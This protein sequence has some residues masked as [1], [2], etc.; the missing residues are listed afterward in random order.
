MLLN[1]KMYTGLAATL[2]ALGVLS[3]PTFAASTTGNAQAVIVTPIAI[4]ESQSM[5]FGS[6]GPD[7][8]ASTVVLDTAGAVSSATADLVPGTGAAA[9][10]FAVTGEANFT[11]AISL[12][13][14]AT[15]TSGANSMTVDTWTTATGSGSATLDGTGNDT[16]NVGATLNVGASQA[17]GTYTGT[18][19][20]TVDYN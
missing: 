8:A 20:I 7:T 12:P 17:A 6:V 13:A 3:S 1:R 19:T 16:I 4:S 11:Y 9:G 10:V 14:S 18:Y 5:N 15:L 2:L